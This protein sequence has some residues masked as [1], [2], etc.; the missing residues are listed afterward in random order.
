MRVE[1]FV[2]AAGAAITMHTARAM[3]T[4]QRLAWVC[5]LLLLV[6]TSASAWLRLAQPRAPCDDWPIC[7]APPAPGAR[8]ADAPGSA[9]VAPV[10]AVHRTAATLALLCIVM[11]VVTWLRSRAAGAS[12]RDARTGA[13]VLALLSIALAL[14]A[15]GIVTPGSR[16]SAVLLGNLLGGLL[17]LAL[18][19]R[20]TRHLGGA[21]SHDAGHRLTRWALAGALLWTVQC[22]LGALSGSGN[23]L[24]PALWHQAFALA[25][26][27]CA[28]IAGR[29]ACRCGLPGEGRALIA[30]VAAQWLLGAGAALFEAAAASVLLHNLT[31]ALGLALLLGLVGRATAAPR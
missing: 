12:G 21:A 22:A 31:A 17:L 7:R 16:A 30:V 14:S 27:F 20:L 26:G 6:V 23:S 29:I 13:L 3:Q 4:M 18:G 9:S 28:L 24:Q 19:W 8:V 15:L 5:V 11:L 1:L 10:R 2:I 25:P